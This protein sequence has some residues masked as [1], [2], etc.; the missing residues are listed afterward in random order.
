MTQVIV[1]CVRTGGAF[2]GKFTGGLS[3]SLS[4]ALAA[5]K[6]NRS[7]RIFNS[8]TAEMSMQ[9]LN[10]L[11]LF[12]SLFIKMFLLTTGGREGWAVDYTVGFTADGA[13]TALKY[14]FYVDAGI[15]ASDTIDSLSMGVTWADN[16]YYV[17]NIEINA[18]VR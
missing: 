4:A 5:S 15:S 11:V 16:A 3:V 8:R 6:L 10:S 7:V 12:S 18:K 2:G 17:P 1:K 13:I 14:A 9:G